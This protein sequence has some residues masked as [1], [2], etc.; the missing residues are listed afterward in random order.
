M[1]GESDWWWCKNTSESTTE[2][3]ELIG[4]YRETMMS[5]LPLNLD[6]DLDLDMD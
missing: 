4:D 3:I 1:V 6:L 2:I 5:M